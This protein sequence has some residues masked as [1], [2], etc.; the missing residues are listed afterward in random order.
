MGESRDPAI[1]R[2]L[3]EIAKD[4][5]RSEH[6][7][8]LARISNRRVSFSSSLPGNTYAYTSSLAN[9]AASDLSLFTTSI[10]DGVLGRADFDLNGETSAR[11]LGDYLAARTST[12]RQT[13]SFN[14]TGGH[15][16]PIF[17][18]SRYGNVYGL[19]IGIS[20]YEQSDRF[21]LLYPAAEAESFHEFLLDRLSLEDEN[22]T[23]LR[24]DEAT[25][26]AIRESLISIR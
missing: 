19:I 16:L 26:N 9:Q 5:G 1:I 22:I 6:E 3:E 25:V 10:I 23:L 15:D 17:D 20:L 8:E 24:D 4:V 7:K 2:D 21:E 18:M 11:E 13:A 12:E 14:I